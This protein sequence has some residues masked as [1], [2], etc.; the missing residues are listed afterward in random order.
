MP[1]LFNCPDLQPGMRLAEAFLFR[2]RVMIPGGKALTDTDVDVLRRKYPDASFRISDP[3][4]DGLVEFEDDSKDR[5]V[6]ASARQK[7]AA[8]VAEVQQRFGAQTS[9]AAV[10]F[11]AMRSAAEDVMDYIA[12]NPVSSALLDQSID[13]ASPMSGHTGNVFYLSIVLGTAVRD[14]VM[15]ERR[16]Q[17]SC[18]FLS[19]DVAMNLLPLGLGAM[20]LDVGM[21]E[22]QRLYA[23]GYV[24]TDAD[25]AAV[26]NHPTKGADLLPDTLPAG[27]KMVVRTH[28]ENFDGTG[29]PNAQPAESLH[30]FTR[31]VRICDAFVA[32]TANRAHR[33]AKPPARVLW[34]MS[35]GPYRG[36]YDP[37]LTKVF[38]GLIQPFPIGAKLRLRD[39]RYAVIV[40]Y[41]HAAPF[42]PTAM[43][44]F[45]KDGERLPEGNITGPVT[46]GGDEFPLGSFEGE[47]LSYVRDLD[48]SPS[49]PPVRF[50]SLVDVAY[51]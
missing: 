17:T 8:C 48:E 47:D 9:L 3:V 15:R 20:F 32:A 14:Y 12:A 28:H 21:Y 4:L 30:V 2:G 37:E 19:N 27:T 36:R 46:I 16:R 38:T 11:N 13:P 42:R 5:D 49:P 23:P 43:I 39:G 40:R 10:N 44:A 41:N 51:P 6:A 35:R 22:L 25:R 26:R 29:Y 33:G 24:L 34:E 31:I 7:V 18:N 1:L 45:D 50:E